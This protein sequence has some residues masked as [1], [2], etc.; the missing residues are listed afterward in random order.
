MLLSIETPVLNSTLSKACLLGLF[1]E[2]TRLPPFTDSLRHD[3]ARCTLVGAGPFPGYS[4]GAADCIE[5]AVEGRERYPLVAS[6]NTRVLLLREDGMVWMPIREL[7][8]GDDIVVPE[9]NGG[10]E[11][12]FWMEPRTVRRM[13][14]VPMP[15]GFDRVRFGQMVVKP[16]GSFATVTAF[17]LAHNGAGEEP[18]R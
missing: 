9:R 18:T 12:G 15:Y 3:G 8:I 17:V 14:R 11:A 2:P 4:L 13:R 5:L 10:G 1:F 6:E 16:H 7:R